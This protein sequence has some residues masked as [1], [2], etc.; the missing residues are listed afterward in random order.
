MNENIKQIS[1]DEIQAKAV[2]SQYDKGQKIQ[3]KE[4]LE[5]GTHVLFSTA[6]N[7]KAKRK[8]VENNIVSIPDEM[9]KEQG[10]LTVNVQIV[11]PNSETTIKTVKVLVKQRKQSEDEISPENQ[12]TFIE[13]IHEIMTET[14]DIA[15][16]V[17]DDADSG[18]FNGQDGF[19]PIATVTKSGDTSKFTVTD[20]NGTTEVDIKDG[21][22]GP[23]GHQGEIG[24]QGP[25]GEPGIDGAIPVYNESTQ[26]LE[27]STGG[28]ADV[29][30][31]MIY[32]GED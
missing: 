16:S 15:Q 26:T 25:Q 5:I 20:K 11:N 14:K 28:L 1:I 32:G 21:E 29:L 12:Q 23:Q 31:N 7:K 19:S 10:T 24:P 6:D 13:Q 27:F 3:F 2:F 22:Q 30:V 9:L 8:V 18:K 4:N 17:R